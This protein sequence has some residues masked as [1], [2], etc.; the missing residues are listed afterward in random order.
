MDPSSGAIRETGSVG[1][2]DYFVVTDVVVL[3]QMVRHYLQALG[4]LDLETCI[5]YYADNAVIHFM[6][7]EYTGKDEITAW[8]RERFENELRAESI[9]RIQG[10]GN[11]VNAE[12]IVSSRRLRKWRIN[13]VRGRGTFLFDEQDKIKDVRFSLITPSFTG[14]GHSK[15]Q[16]RT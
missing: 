14:S 1:I 4:K 16:S 7:G 2:R 8:H 13:K 11:Q 10:N 12:M 5:S 6:T 3:E 15:E 9:E